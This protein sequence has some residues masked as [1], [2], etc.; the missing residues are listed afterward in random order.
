[1]VNGVLLRRKS[2][3]ERW[4]DATGELKAQKFGLAEAGRV[5]ASR[6]VFVCRAAAA[7]V[8]AAKA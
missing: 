1:M 6:R 5:I 2:V 7:R 8:Y 3:L 4:M